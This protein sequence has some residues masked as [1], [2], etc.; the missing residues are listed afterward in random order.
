MSFSDISSLMG[1]LEF[2]QF[3]G[4]LREVGVSACTLVL[5]WICMDI[6]WHNSLNAMVDCWR[7]LYYGLLVTLNFLPSLFRGTAAA[8]PSQL[9]FW[10]CAWHVMA[11]HI[12]FEVP[13]Q[14]G[15]PAESSLPA[16][17]VTLQSVETGGRSLTG[18]R[19]SLKVF[20]WWSF[21]GVKMTCVHY[22]IYCRP[23]TTI[24]THVTKVAMP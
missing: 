2:R 5:F 4:K 10:S 16:V 8:A 21:C 23:Y 6:L 12:W 22:I 14:L 13:S 1:P 19:S 20:G 18:W 9:G 7:A 17:F 24:W 11:A 15:P 3:P